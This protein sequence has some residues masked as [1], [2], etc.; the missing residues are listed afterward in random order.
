MC[1]YM[2]EHKEG[3]V[4]SIAFQYDKLVIKMINV[5]MHEFFPR[6]NKLVIYILFKNGKLCF[7]KLRIH[8]STFN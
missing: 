8:H 7:I 2:Y 1:P 6:Y 3:V 5:Y 4:I